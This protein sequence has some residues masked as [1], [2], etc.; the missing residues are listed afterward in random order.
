VDLEGEGE[1][2]KDQDPLLY[3]GKGEKRVVSKSRLLG[4]AKRGKYG[5]F[6][7]ATQPPAGKKVLPS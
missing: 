5:L 3:G 4:E 1:R 7:S 2:K 6:L